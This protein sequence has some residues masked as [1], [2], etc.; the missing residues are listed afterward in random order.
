MLGVSKDDPTAHDRFVADQDLPF[1][2]L[3]DPEATTT[4]AYGAW[5][6]KSSY[7]K[8]TTGAIRSTVVIG[9]NG[10]VLKHWPAVRKVDLHPAEVLAF[11]KRA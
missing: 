9:P 1:V 10:R 4:K 8:P 7:G 2:L 6:A 11:L 5:G 3:S